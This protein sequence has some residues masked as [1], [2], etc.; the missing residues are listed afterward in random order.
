MGER[1]ETNRPG[2]YPPHAPLTDWYERPSDRLDYVQ[3]LFNKSAPHYDTVEKLFLNGGIH[4]RRL[5]LAFN[6]LKPGMKVLDVAVG[7]AAVSM[8][9]VRILGP[10]GRVVGVDPN[11]GMLREARE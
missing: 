10:Q 11:P 4:Y 8:G 5:S 2:E 1:H 6:G 7:T 9:A 3:D